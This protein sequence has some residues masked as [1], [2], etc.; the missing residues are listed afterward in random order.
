MK[1][2]KKNWI[3]KKFQ[4]NNLST[5]EG[6]QI[7]AE[8]RN[9]DKCQS[10]P[11]PTLEDDKGIKFGDIKTIKDDNEKQAEKIENERVQF[12]KGVG[13]YDKFGNFSN[14]FKGTMTYIINS[15]LE[16]G[17]ESLIH[18]SQPLLPVKLSME[19][20]GIGGLRVGDLFKVDYLPQ[21]YRDFCTVYNK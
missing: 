16:D 2:H 17:S 11:I 1:Y 9:L 21:K 8:V 20:D 14:Y 4:E 10:N 15:S 18:R 6:W 7:A 13:I 5:K 3:T 12:I 19:L